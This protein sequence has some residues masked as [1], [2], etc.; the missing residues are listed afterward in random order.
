MIYT[1]LLPS[2][3]LRKSEVFYLFKV[4]VHY[5]RRNYVIGSN[6]GSLETECGGVNFIRLAQ[7]KFYWR[8]PRP[9][10]EIS[11]VHVWFVVENVTLGQFYFRVSW[12]V[13][14][15][16]IPPTLQPH[17]LFICH[18]RNIILSTG[19]YVDR[20]TQTNTREQT[21]LVGCF[22]CGSILYVYKFFQ[23]FRRNLMILIARRVTCNKFHTEGPQILGVTVQNLVA[24]ELFNF[25]LNYFFCMN[26][27]ILFLSRT[28]ILE[29]IGPT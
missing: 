28:L 5:N 18:R 4:P 3:V 23:K 29:L 11:P 9:G 10:L 13:S 20:N 21:K 12:F 15:S 24:P 27:I 7:D 16:I 2:N 8:A 25:I 19:I 17:I 26:W 22:E 14:V 1:S 6:M